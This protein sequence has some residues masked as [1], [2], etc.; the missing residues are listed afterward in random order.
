MTE[1]IEKIS[2]FGEKNTCKYLGILEADTIK[3]AEMK[4]KNEKKISEN[5]KTTQNQTT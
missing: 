4:E 2:P 5:E 3:Q 1:G